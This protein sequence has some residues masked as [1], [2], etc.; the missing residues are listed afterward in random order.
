[1][2]RFLIFTASI[3]FSHSVYAKWDVGVGAATSRPPIKAIDQTYEAIPLIAYEGERWNFQI[4]TLS[5]QIH[6]WGD[7]NLSAQIAGRFD[8]YDPEDSPYLTGMSTRR[9]TLDYG[10]SLNWNGFDF[11]VS[12]DALGEH[13]GQTISFGYGNGIEMG[14]W[15]FMP[16]LAVN[17]QS[18]KR[19]NYYYGVAPDEVA[20]L[21]IDNQVFN[22][23][24]Y[25]VDSQVLVPE[26]SLLVMYHFNSSWFLIG[27][28]SVEF[29]PEDITK[30]PLV[31]DDMGWGMFIGIAKH[32]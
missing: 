26:A 28:G 24:A 32:F 18:E 19:I 15:M 20:T 2:N 10:F 16:Q 13:D 30:S 7:L 8:G 12:Q 6:Q 11:I 31:D 29:Y 9:A 17:W 21:T 1:M 23:T 4:T 3:L 27:G 25:A 5:Y 14:K 22:R